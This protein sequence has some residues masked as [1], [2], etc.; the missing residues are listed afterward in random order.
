MFNLISIILSLLTRV[1]MQ[2]SPQLVDNWYGLIDWIINWIELESGQW[3]YPGAGP[4]LHLFR[5][6]QHDSIIRFDWIKFKCGRHLF[7]CFDFIACIFQKNQ[8]KRKLKDSPSPNIPPLPALPADESMPATFTRSW[9]SGTIATDSG[10]DYIFTLQTSKKAAKL[11][12]I[13]ALQQWDPCYSSTPVAAPPPLHWPLDRW[14]PA[15]YRC[16]GGYAESP[17]LAPRRPTQATVGCA[18]T[19]IDNLFKFIIIKR[20]SSGEN[21]NTAI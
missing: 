16:P 5:S 17:P 11:I 9:S 10:I 8:K 19:S 12:G 14:P 3:V 21:N 13:N 7:H 20:T 18:P 4:V 2:M 6:S 15:P 1:R